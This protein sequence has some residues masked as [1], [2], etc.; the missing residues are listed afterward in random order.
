MRFC[1]RAVLA[2]ATAALS[3]LVVGAAGA[4]VGGQRY[5]CQV[6]LVELNITVDGTSTGV[7]GLDC[8]AQLP[9]GTAIEKTKKID[10]Q[11]TILINASGK[12]LAKC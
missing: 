6:A 9:D 5:P 7:D 3:L 10:G 4:D 2:S 8:Q 11:C 1:I 12:V